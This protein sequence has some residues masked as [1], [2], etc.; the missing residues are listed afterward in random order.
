MLGGNQQRN[1]LENLGAGGD[2]FSIPFLHDIRN[3]PQAQDRYE[4]SSYAVN[5]LFGQTEIGLN[6]N[7]FI[8]GSLRNDWFSTLTQAPGLDSENSKLYYGLGA[9]WVL[10]DAVTLP[11]WADFA[12][13]RAGYAQ[14]GGATNPYQLTLNYGVFGDFNGQPLGGVTSG[15][16]PNSMLVPSTSTEFEVGGDFRFMKGRVN[17]D[18][19]YY[20]RK[21][22]DDILSASASGASGFGTITVNVGEIRNRGIEAL[23]SVTP[24][25]NDKLDWTVSLNYAN[26]QN[27]VVSLLTP[28]NDGEMLSVDGSR[29]LSAN[30][31]HIE[32]LPYSQITG[33]TYMRDEGGN[34]MYD[35][36][37]LPRI[38]NEVTAFGTGVHPT[39]IGLN[40]SLTFGNFSVSA[41]LDFR[42]GAFIYTA[43]NSFAYT[44]GLHKNTLEGR[45][46]GRIGDVTLEPAN[47][48]DYYQRVA[49]I[50]EQFV[51][52][53][54]YAKLR[55]V[56]LSYR[57]PSSI[58]GEGVIRGAT[59]SLTGR[60]LA[61]L[62]SSVENV[63]PESTYN[64]GNAQGLEMFGVPQTRS[65]GVNLNVKF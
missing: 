9:S 25:R 27:E 58:F 46:D 17:L 18:L 51:D 19:A 2:N 33:F 45:E 40:N 28:E 10:S 59:I 21:T 52:E 30:I 20:N 41:L 61:L 23:L 38:N 65:F 3:V 14:V 35:E 11:A 15:S 6:N 22:V 1:K 47:V 63:D 29:T 50:T 7:L 36:D 44:R 56:I 48:Q 57:L 62:Y 37:N 64:N 13:L 26:N 8:T 55:E 32:G 60:N 34:I 4:F 39:T 54:N 42:S 53:S 12:K 49:G 43:T 5:S 24:V 31:Q 16:I